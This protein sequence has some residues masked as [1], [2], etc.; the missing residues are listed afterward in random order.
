MTTLA[1]LSFIVS[2]ALF[3]QLYLQR[4]E[5]EIAQRQWQ[6]D[7]DEILKILDKIKKTQA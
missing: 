4:K 2:V 1:S 6:K 7:F 5:Q 3:V